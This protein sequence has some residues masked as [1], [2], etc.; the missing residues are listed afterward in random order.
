MESDSALHGDVPDGAE[1][2][3]SADSQ[4]ESNAE[5]SDNNVTSNESGAAAG[6]FCIKIQS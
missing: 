1:V 4:P 6:S 5:I 3:P 2:S